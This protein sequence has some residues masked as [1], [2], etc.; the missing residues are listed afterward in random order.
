MPAKRYRLKPP[1]PH[2]VHA[3]KWTGENREEM[4]EFCPTIMGF[5][6]DCQMSLKTV[7]GPTIISEGYYVVKDDKGFTTVAASDFELVYEEATFYP[8]SFRPL[9]TFKSNKGETFGV[10]RAK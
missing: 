5:G 1:K 3:L 4:K 6:P 8:S 7:N 2:D 9:Y 10:F